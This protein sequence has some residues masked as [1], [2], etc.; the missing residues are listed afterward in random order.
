MQRWNTN[1]VKKIVKVVHQGL[2]IGEH[3]VGKK[4]PHFWG[5]SGCASYGADVS[6]SSGLW[7]F[8][9]VT[10]P[11]HILTRFCYILW[12]SHHSV[13]YKS[14]GQKLMPKQIL[15]I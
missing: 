14:R 4:Y 13:D 1:E 8:T 12:G 6:D 2:K 3:A 5:A 11:H 15:E 9:D 7:E 10:E